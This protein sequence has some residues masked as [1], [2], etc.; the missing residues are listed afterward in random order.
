MIPQMGLWICGVLVGLIS[1][2]FYIYSA[3]PYILTKYREGPAIEKLKGSNWAQ[4]V[5]ESWSIYLRMLQFATKLGKN[6]C[7]LNA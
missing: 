3:L 2:P 4:E 6:V 7:C 1:V 5:P